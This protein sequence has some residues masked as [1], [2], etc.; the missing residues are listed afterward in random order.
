MLYQYNF[1]SILYGKKLKTLKKTTILDQCEVDPD[2]RK[3]CGFMGI[4]QPGC[5]AKGCCWRPLENGSKAPWC[6]F[7]AAKGKKIIKKVW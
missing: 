6:F 4:K 3:E 1:L 2:A 5:E 7:P